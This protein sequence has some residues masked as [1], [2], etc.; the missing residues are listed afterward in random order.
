VQRALRAIHPH[1]PHSAL[2]SPRSY[3]CPG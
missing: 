1:G 2:R 3:M